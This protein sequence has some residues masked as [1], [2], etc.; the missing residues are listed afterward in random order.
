VRFPRNERQPVR[1]LDN[2]TAVIAKGKRPVPF[3][4]RKLSPSAPMVLHS[5]GCG[6]VGR[7]RTPFRRSHPTR[8]GFFCFY[9]HFVRCAHTL[10]A[11]FVGFPAVRLGFR[12]VRF[13]FPRFAF[14]A[15]RCGWPLDGAVRLSGGS[16]AARWGAR[17]GQLVAELIG[18]GVNP[19][20]ARAI[21]WSWYGPLIVGAVCG[22]S[23]PRSG[24]CATR[25]SVRADW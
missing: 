25:D 17:G 16:R 1:Q 22:S 21:S 19:G 15:G 11:P 23:R 2:V 6:R 12:P 5:P 3:R 8:G 18:W 10:R 13:R 9:P 14:A 7:R 20:S 24:M 4:T